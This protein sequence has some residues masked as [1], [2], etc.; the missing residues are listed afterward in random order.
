M[1]L[2]IESG[3]ASTSRGELAAL[4]GVD[5]LSF[6][7]LDLAQSLGHP[8]DPAH[9]DVKAR[10]RRRAS[11]R[12]RAAGKRVRED[13]M[14]YVWIN[15]VLIAPAAHASSLGKLP[16]I[17]RGGAMI[18][19]DV[20][21]NTKYGRQP[22]FAACPD[23]PGAFPAIILYMDAPGFREELRDQARRIAKHGYF[24]L[25]PDLYY[26]LGTLRFD[27]PRRND[28]MS[29]VIRG[30]DAEPDQRRASTDDTGGMIAFL[31]GQDKVKPGP[32]GC[33][34]H[35]MSGPFALTAAA[36][37]PR[38]K[39][40]A[41]LYGVD[42]VTD[43]P[44]SPHLLRRATI[45]GELYV[46]FAGDR[47]RGAGDT[48][49]PRS[50]AALKNAGHEARD[51]DVSPDTHHGFCFAARPTTTRSPPRRRWDDA[52][53]PVGPQPQVDAAH[54]IR[55]TIPGGQIHYE[56]H[57]ERLPG[58]AVR[59]GIPEL[60]HR[61]LA[62]Q[63]REARRAAGLARSDRR[64]VAIDF[65][66]I[67][68][69]VRN[70]GQSR[71]TLEPTRRLDERT[72]A[73]HLALL[74]H[75]GVDALSRRWARASACRSRFALAK[76]AAGR[77]CRALVL[78]NPIG[79]S[80]GQ[81]RGARPRVRQVGRAKCAAGRT[82]TPALLPGFRKRMFGGDFIFSV[83]REFVRALRDSDAADARRRPRAS[84]RRLGRPRARAGRR[85]AGAVERRGA[86]RRA[87]CA[88]CANS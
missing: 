71:A 52:L 30:V 5:Y 14:K 51:G 40:A 2:M 69:D 13:F 53:R 43:K 72:R 73:D 19:Q 57:G 85:G 60:A 24:C 76:R 74:D 75:L 8:G 62:H 32:L 63:S 27:I 3:A 47:S 67:A 58:A 41:A 42:M 4:P 37:F 28:A 23:A 79:L 55:S 87:R 83:S 56:V 86:A 31:D 16:R 49:C 70:A 38:M 29:A 9:A 12:I 35:C 68:L 1:C 46:G 65:Q 17:R 45:K 39:A 6:G 48:S 26:R 20:V 10:R 54:A 34:G 33:V 84:R 11:K 81:S 64:A 59:A 44:D 77:S 78:Q 80:A 82:S 36:R 7:M 15:D 50:K 22:G 88:A 66:L 21:I 18:E 25:L 61:A